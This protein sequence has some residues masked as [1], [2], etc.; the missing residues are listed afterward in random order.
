MKTKIQK[1]TELFS[2]LV[3]LFYSAGVPRSRKISL[4]R[5]N[6]SAISFRASPTDSRNA[7]SPNRRGL[8]FL[9]TE[10]FKIFSAL[11]NAENN[12]LPVRATSF[13]A[14]FLLTTCDLHH[15]TGLSIGKLIQ[16]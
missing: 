13:F 2:D 7:I 11:K 16:K 5:G 3:F 14:D 1:Q 8:P 9:F 6:A 4:P 15:I 10:P 12:C